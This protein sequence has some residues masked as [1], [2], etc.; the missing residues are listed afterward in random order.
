MRHRQSR[1]ALRLEMLLINSTGREFDAM[2]GIESGSLDLLK[3][4]PLPFFCW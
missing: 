1:I 4:A 3:S 2:Y